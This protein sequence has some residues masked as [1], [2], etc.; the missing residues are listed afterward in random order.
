M[1]RKIAVVFGGTGFV[2]RYVV[3]D[4]AAAGYQ[5]KVASRV[6]E[7][8]YDLK[9]A[10][11]V[12]QIVP[13]CCDYADYDSI[14][15]VVDGADCVV[16]CIGILF[17]KK[18]GG[19]QRIHAELPEAI[20]AACAVGG[21]RKFVH[22]SAL[23]IVDSAS[24]YA[25]S[26]REGEER[27]LKVCPNVAI[28]RPSVIFGEEDNFFNQFAQLASVLPFLPLFGGGHTKFQPVYVGDVA[29]AVVRCVKDRS[30]TGGVVYELGGPEVIDFK[31]V[32][33]Q[34]FEYTGQRCRM[35]SIPFC[36]ASAQAVLL[37]MM[38]KPLLT[39]DQ[40]ESLKTDSIV[41]YDEKSFKDLGMMPVSMD[42]VLPRYLVNY[43]P[44]GRFAA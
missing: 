19:F 43:R 15:G 14:A 2:G 44:G 29:E 13:V 40:V 18:R 8:G 23:G 42:A 35:V 9:P 11:D 33:E 26:K 3:R 20:A 32:Y 31:G 24:R 27:I 4:L 38:P 34:I 16:N 36:V 28:L 39:T 1:K 21:V 30:A 37:G 25:V 17:E 41:S 7:R 22:I 10:G 6:P 12:G 5:I